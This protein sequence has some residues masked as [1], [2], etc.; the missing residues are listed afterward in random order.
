MGGWVGVCVGVC[1]CV[2]VCVGVCGCVHFFSC[3]TCIKTNKQ[4]CTIK[5]NNMCQDIL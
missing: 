3:I 5:C 4:I 2:W 1:G